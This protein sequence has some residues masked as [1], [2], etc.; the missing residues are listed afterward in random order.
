VEKERK[1]NLALITTDMVING[2]STV[3]MN[4]CRYIDLKRF[5][6]TVMAGEPVESIYQ[7]NLT[8]LGIEVCVFPSRRKHPLQYLRELKKK[9]RKSKF[10]ILH[11][12][13]NSA[14]VTPEIFLG[15]RAKIPIRIVHSHNTTCSYLLAHRLLYPFFKL[16]YTHGF[17]CSQAAGKW[18]FREKSFYVIPNGFFTESFKYDSSSRT[19]IRKELQI[20][21][22]ELLL[23]HVGRFNEQKNHV[24]LLHVFEEI[25]K[26]NNS[27]KLIL[28][29][30]G[31]KRDEI[32]QLIEEQNYR[33]KIILYGESAEVEKLYAAMDIFVLPS[34]HEGLGIVLLEAQISGLPCVSADVV[35]KEVCLG[36]NIKFLSLEDSFE[37][38]GKTILE[39]KNENRELFYYDNIEEIERYNIKSNSVVL[40]EIYTNLFDE[41]KGT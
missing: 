23:G 14:T 27:V 40:S 15:Y 26:Q 41:Y 19:D 4:Y 32:C 38:W 17:A 31:P 34:K 16:I 2:V 37:Q 3:I 20:A 1:I 8:D 13:C 10:D 29:G 35:P 33:D 21:D 5:N 36:K 39:M 25:L 28:I 7:A 9:F 12:H 24:L 22:S 30:D 11:I 6:I 18:L